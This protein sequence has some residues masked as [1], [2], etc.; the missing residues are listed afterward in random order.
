MGN[1]EPEVDHEITR[2]E[3]PTIT[4]AEDF[5]DD[6]G[7]ASSQVDAAP[8]IEAKKS[9]HEVIDIDSSSPTVTPKAEP[10][11][12]PPKK[13]VAPASFYAPA[14]KTKP[15]GPLYVPYSLHPA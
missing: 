10:S 7:L 1:K 8:F 15:K 13:Y 2:A 6:I 4:G 11:A 9:R 3:M 12:P 5:D 14:Q